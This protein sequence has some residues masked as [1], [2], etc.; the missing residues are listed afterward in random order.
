MPHRRAPSATSDGHTDLVFARDALRIAI[1]TERS[2]LEFYTR[3]AKVTQDARGRKVF[4]DLALEEKEHLGTLEARY[5]ELLQRDPQLESRPTFL[6]FKGA[7]NGLFAEGAERLMRGVNDQQALMIGIRCERGSHRFFKKYGERFEDSEGK[8]I[9]LEFADEE[10]E[11]LD[12]LVREYRA[13]VKRQGRS[14]RAVGRRRQRAVRARARVAADRPPPPHDRLRRPLLAGASSSTAPPPPVSRVMAVTDHDTTA[15]V[16]EVRAPRAGARHRGGR[17]HRDH[18]RRGRPRRPHARL[19][20]RS[21]R[22]GARGVPGRSSVPAASSRVEAIAAR[23][24]ALGHADRPRRRCSPRRGGSR[25]R[26][27]GRPQVAR[28]MIAAGYVADTARRSMRWL[29]P[30]LPAFVPRAG[31]SADARDRH[32]ARRRRPGVAG[33]SGPD[34]HRRAHPALRDAGLDASRSFTPITTTRLA[35][36]IAAWRAPLG[37][38]VTG[39]SDFHGDPARGLEP[40]AAT[41]PVADW[42]RLDAARQRHAVR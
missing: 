12:L 40:G 23:L 37:L 19:L 18:R 16:A 17:R 7:A 6:F 4:Q 13:L 29:G 9:F 33:T 8:Q 31:A 30:G 34:A 38:L 41:L 25:A 20:L 22:C 42:Q 1:A 21:G 5:N 15:G 39:G 36:A 35:R 2:G 14:R 26:S 32:H 10:R 11:H 28:A 24:A 3:A 27:I